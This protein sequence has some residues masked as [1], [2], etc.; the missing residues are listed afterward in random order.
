MRKKKNNWKR[1][2]RFQLRKNKK[3]KKE[4]KEKQ[5]LEEEEKEEEEEEEDRIKNEQ[6]DEAHNS[7]EFPLATSYALF[8]Y[9]ENNYIDTLE[10]TDIYELKINQIQKKKKKK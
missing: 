5:K 8:Q 9:P 7:I 3:L 6:I 10:S 2:N 1:K 4:K